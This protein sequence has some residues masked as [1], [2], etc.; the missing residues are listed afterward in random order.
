MHPAQS[1]LCNVAQGTT[2]T[3]QMDETYCRYLGTAQPMW[4]CSWHFSVSLGGNVKS[5]AL[6]KEKRK[7]HAPAS[8]A[9]GGAIF[10]L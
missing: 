9:L 5:G 7:E 1:H 4:K 3:T 10:S 6:S 8:Q 2:H